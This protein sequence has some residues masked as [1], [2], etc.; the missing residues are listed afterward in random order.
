MKKDVKQTIPLPMPNKG[1]WA[2]YL[3]IDRRN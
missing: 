3:F 2:A 1:L